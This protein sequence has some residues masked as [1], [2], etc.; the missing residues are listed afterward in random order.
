MLNWMNTVGIGQEAGKRRKGSRKNDIRVL[1]SPNEGLT[2]QK[3][4][5]DRVLTKLMSDR[6]W[7]KEFLYLKL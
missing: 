2:K 6:P 7:M 4:D 3:R 5:L 1:R